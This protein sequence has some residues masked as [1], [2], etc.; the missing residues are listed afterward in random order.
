MDLRVPREQ[1]EFEHMLRVSPPAL[2]GISLTFTSNG[3][4]AIR[5]A[6]V[7]RW[8][9][10]KTVI[11]LGGTGASEDPDAF[12]DT[13]VDFIGY[14]HSDGSLAEL[15]RELRRSGS[16]RE[17]APGFFHRAGDA[18]FVGNRSTRFPWTR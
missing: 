6:S 8:A 14:R 13:D 5:I 7:V 4:E 10:P 1:N 17:N 11:V 12:Y 16:T 18:G 9:S 15:V 2:V 3:D